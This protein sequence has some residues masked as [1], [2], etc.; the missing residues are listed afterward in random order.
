MEIPFVKSPVYMTQFQK[1]IGSTTKTLYIFEVKVVGWRRLLFEDES[2]FAV[3]YITS[4]CNNKI[5]RLIFAAD[6]IESF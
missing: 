4:G 1:I 3:G 2:G 6:Y 5:N